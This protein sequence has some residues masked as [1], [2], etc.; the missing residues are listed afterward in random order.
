MS[1]AFLNE[2]RRKHRK[3]PPLSNLDYNCMDRASIK[4]RKVLDSLQLERTLAGTKLVPRNL[5]QQHL[6]RAFED[7]A[8]RLYYETVVKLDLQL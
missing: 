7:K 8:S 6:W 4:L 2:E 1:I 5:K 3:L